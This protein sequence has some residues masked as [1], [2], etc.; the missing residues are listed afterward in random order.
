[1]ADISTRLAR[2][3]GARV[4]LLADCCY[5]GDLSEVAANSS[6]LAFR[7]TALS[8]ASSSNISTGNWTFTQN[9][10]DALRGRAIF[11]LD[12]DGRI[13]LAELRDEV[14]DAMK[15]REGQRSGWG[16]PGGNAELILA[17]VAP[18]AKSAARK[19]A[20]RGVVAPHP[21]TRRKVPPR[22]TEQ[23]PCRTWPV[24][25]LLKVRWNKDIYSARVTHVDDGFMQITY[26]GW[27]AVWDEWITAERVLGPASAPVAQ[28]PLVPRK[29][30]VRGKGK[31]Y[32]AEILRMEGKKHCV[33]YAGFDA[34]WDECVAADRVKPI[35]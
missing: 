13:T 3:K 9:V 19:T 33:H 5:S 25:S 24:S 16:D 30:S 18:E 8:S 21:K 35:Q 17:V 12:Y 14:R 4:L 28:S 1:M 2:F 10:I 22:S 29:L 15:Y 20:E 6:P 27:D 34:R 32:E 7:L 23:Q 31:W 11:D 26:P